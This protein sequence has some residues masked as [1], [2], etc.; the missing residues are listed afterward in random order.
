MFFKRKKSS[1]MTAEQLRKL[2]KTPLKYVT[3]RDGE[4]AREIKLGD[5]GAINVRDGDFALV[6][7]GKDVF[8]A[9]LD[10]VKAGELMNLSGLTLSYT[11]EKG[12]R[13]SVVAYYSDGHIPRR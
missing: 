10:K 12:V 4:T 5:N 3:E 1:S 9:R 11:D 6:C 7:G 2:D 8:R 13:R